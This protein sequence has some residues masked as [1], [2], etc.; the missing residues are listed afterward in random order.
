MQQKTETKVLKQRD[1]YN[2]AGLPS[3]V[4]QNTLYQ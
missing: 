1:K 2:H 3:Y 4:W